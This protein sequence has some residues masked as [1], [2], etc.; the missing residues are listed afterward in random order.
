M[1]KLTLAA[2]LILAVGLTW[3]WWS[4][5]FDRLAYQAVAIQRQ[6]QVALAGAI[7]HLKAGQPG[8]VTGLIALCFGYGVVHAAGPG[9]G[10]ML[11]GGYALSNR[12]PLPRLLTMTLA[13]SLAQA[14]TAVALVYA[15]VL[16]F[17]W[18]RTQMVDMAE[19]SLT[20]ASYAAIGLIGLYLG[21]RGARML[22][23][24]GAGEPQGHGHHH[25]DDDHHEQRRARPRRA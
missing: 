17:D 2:G 15:G 11:V 21:L 6:F 9:H 8:A 18:T 23:R 22:W 20:Q 14:A 12:V 1:R 19:R 7:R 3:A 24:A 16:V 4:G 10:K 25:H 5:G 13:A